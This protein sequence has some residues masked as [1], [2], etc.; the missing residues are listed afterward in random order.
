M[1]GFGGRPDTSEAIEKALDESL[2][3]LGLEYASVF[4]TAR[5]VDLYYLHRCP[6]LDSTLNFLRTAIKL[7]ETGKIRHIGLS[8][9]PA[10]WLSEAVK[11]A[12]I[13]ALQMEWSA[14]TRS[15]ESE[16]SY[17]HLNTLPFLLLTT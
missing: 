5:Y 6:S 8:E 15:V 1:P 4:L 14:V 17:L 3:R 11:V 10:A 7:Q 2:E 13:A 12:P 16:V 9:T